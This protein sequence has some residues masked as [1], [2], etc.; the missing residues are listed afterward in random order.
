MGLNNASAAAASTIDPTVGALLND[1]RT[2][3]T[4]TG[5][6]ESRDANLDRLTFNNAVESKRRFPT[7]RLDY[8][9]TDNHRFTT[10]VNYNWFTDAP[11][12]LNGYDQQ[13][14]GFPV[15]AGQSSTRLGWSNTLRSTLGRNFVNEARVGYSGSP[16]AFFDELNPS[17]YSDTLANQ[18]GVHL[19][20]P[21]IGAQLTPASVNAPSPQSRNAT[22]LA[23]EDTVTWLKG[24][25]NL[26][27]GV[28][29]TNY[30]V[31][32][33]NSSLV[34]RVTFGLLTNDPASNVIT[35]ASLQAATGLA[36]SAAQLT[37]AQNLYA[38]LTGRMSAINADARLNENTGEYEYIGLGIQ[39]S[40]M[41]E[42][43]VFVQDSWRIKSNVTINAGLRYDVQFPFTASNNSYS[44][45]TLADVCGRSGI[46]S[47]T[48]YCNLFQPGVMPGKTPQ[49]F[50]LEK[51]KHAYNTDWDNFAPN[52]GMA[53]TPAARSGFLGKL[54]SE[55]FVVRAGFARAY[56]R[57]GM[58][59]FTGIYNANP[60]VRVTVDRTSGLT[61]GNSITSTT[62][63]SAP[64]LFRN[65][66]NLAPGAF[67]TTPTYPLT[68]VVTEDIRCSIRTSRSPTRTPGRREFS[69]SCPPTWRSKCATSAPAPPTLD[70]EELQRDQHPREQLPR[71]IPAGP[72]Q[73]CGQYRRRSRQHFAYTGA[74]GT[75][76]CRSS[77]RIT[78]AEP[79]PTRVTPRFTPAPTGPIRRSSGSW[80]RRTRTR[81]ALRR[82][83]QRPDRQ[84]TFRGNAIAAGLAANHFV[85]NPDLI[86]GASIN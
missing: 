67:A 54:M 10:A 18:K 55:E 22:D 4:S 61:G 11:D 53:W 24:N 30:N 70:G 62:G 63:G 68:D 73:P 27:T 2:A 74:P 1:I 50:N 66:A 14:P 45:P 19:N 78:T 85:A 31:W 44:T 16:V 37:Q 3:A 25:H 36:P 5:G 28:S 42:T 41:K 6:L 38:F 20:F 33:K 56:S 51:G 83:R 43:G 71:G 29:W 57:N 81:T 21:S 17:M 86:G 77:W 40:A 32:L 26:T 80:R 15:A 82:Q 64:V 65:D 60:G 34:P 46:D 52:V 79:R 35:T 84:R 48:G 49:F 47:A 39:R 72:G 8:N 23:I 7:F 12:T 13:W 59:D 69:A 76:R 75:G 9:I 58:G